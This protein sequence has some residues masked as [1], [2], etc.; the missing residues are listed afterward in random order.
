MTSNSKKHFL[1]FL[2][3]P[4]VLVFSTTVFSQELENQT[5][6]DRIFCTDSEYYQSDKKSFRELRE[7][8]IAAAGTIAVDGKRN[9]GISV[10]GENRSDVLVRAC[11]QSYDMPQAEAA[12]LARNL[13]IETNST[14]RAEGISDDAK[15]SVSYQI[16]VPRNSNLDLKAYNGGI[17]I[18]AVEGNIEFSTNNGGISVR[19]VAGS[20]KGRTQNGGVRAV[21]SGTS[22]RGGG[23][24]L[25]TTN[26]GI[27][28]E[29]P[30]NY[31]ARFETG[32][33]NGGVKS[34]IDGLN[35]PEK[36]R[37]G[38][39]RSK[40]VAADLNGGGPLVRVV[41]TNGGVNI[42]TVGVKVM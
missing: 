41:T 30:A 34:R 19:E 9:G 36:E 42:D 23:L 4:L 39:M 17:S 22:W 38:G 37:S 35:F 14:I 31:S 40:R 7:T 15:I 12:A 29:V 24:D 16:L 6:K 10:K 8:T 3:L 20:V 25:E 2:L 27:K 26:G 32:T 21:L 33:V 13:R 5:G 11:I 18:S 28:V 1:R